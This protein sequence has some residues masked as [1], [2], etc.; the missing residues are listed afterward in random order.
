MPALKRVCAILGSPTS[1]EKCAASKRRA[2]STQDVKDGEIM[3]TENG[4]K[5]VV[6]PVRCPL[7]DITND[8][9]LYMHPSQSDTKPKFVVMQPVVVDTILSQ[10]DIPCTPTRRLELEDE[11]MREDAACDYK[12]QIQSHFLDSE[13]KDLPRRGF[14]DGHPE[15]T[16]HK[17]MVLIDWLTDIHRMNDLRHE[18]LFLAMSIFDR[19]LSK[20]TTPVTVSE[21]QFLAAA[22]LFLASKYEDVDPPL[23]ADLARI[24]GGGDGKDKIVAWE[25]K[26]LTVLDFNLAVPT[27]YSFL[28]R[29]CLTSASREGYVQCL[30]RDEFAEDMLSGESVQDLCSYFAERTLYNADHACERPSQL[31][32]LALRAASICVRAEGELAGMSPREGTRHRTAQKI[33]QLVRTHLLDPFRGLLVTKKGPHSSELKWQRQSQIR[34]RTVAHLNAVATNCA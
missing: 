12:D 17:R 7:A 30:A 34:T 2:I 21:V 31:A 25:A 8:R 1:A 28:R 23:L 3:E 4:N 13:T 33:D 27:V 5:M 19:F 11:P 32:Q 16:K 22:C 14:L 15:L 9:A 20:Y 24:V 26:I 29:L 6:Q 18:S 10:D